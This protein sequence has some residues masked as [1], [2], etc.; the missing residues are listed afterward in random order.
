M[1]TTCSGCSACVCQPWGGGEALVIALFFLLAKRVP[2]TLLVKGSASFGTVCVAVLVVV[3][4]A[5]VPSPAVE[6]L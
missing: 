5:S 6:G 2:P 3:Y 1:G 4:K